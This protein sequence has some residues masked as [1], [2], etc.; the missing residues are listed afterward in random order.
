MIA[1]SVIVVS[2]M[3]V[4]ERNKHML[5]VEEDCFCYECCP[6]CGAEIVEV[7]NGPN[8]HGCHSSSYYCV[9][10]HLIES[11]DCGGHNKLKR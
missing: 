5:E 3:V 10:G 6:H 9:N 8:E 1:A 4:T 7:M 11:Y 2:V